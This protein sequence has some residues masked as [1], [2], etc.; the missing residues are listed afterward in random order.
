MKYLKNL[1]FTNG[2][3]SKKYTN[4]FDRT[5]GH[6]EQRWCDRCQAETVHYRTSTGVKKADRNEE[7]VWICTQCEDAMGV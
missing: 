2:H 6:R 4:N 1:P 5:F 3:A 7:P